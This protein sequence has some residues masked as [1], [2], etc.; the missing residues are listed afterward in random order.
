MKR[1][2]SHLIENQKEKSKTVRDHF[3]TSSQVTANSLV[4]TACAFAISLYKRI[5]HFPT[6][7]VTQ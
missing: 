1:F 3:H 6:G 2:S 7:L 5:A 4:F